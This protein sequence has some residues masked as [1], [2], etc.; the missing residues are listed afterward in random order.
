M[1]WYKT[2]QQ[3]H[4]NFWDGSQK[5]KYEIK[6]PNDFNPS[7]PKGFSIQIQPDTSIEDYIEEA[8]NEK[9]LLFLFETF[10]EHYDIYTLKN[11]E[12]VL[13]YDDKIIELS[14]GY[15]DIQNAEQWV[16]DQ[17]Q[18]IHEY[19]D[20]RDFNEEFWSGVGP[21]YKMYHG[22]TNE[23]IDNILKVGLNPRNGTRGISN[24]SIGAGIFMSPDP[25]T[26]NY[27]YD[28]VV[29]IDVGQMKKDGYTPFVSG[30]TPVDDAILLEALAHQL[31]I[32]S[33]EAMSQFSSDG[34]SQD[35][36]VFYKKIPPKYLKEFNLS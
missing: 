35:T 32:P 25:M 31:D 13:R 24:R 36:I 12:R 17:E 4:F 8:K 7:I 19:V 28:K 14:N 16:W 18:N 30:E 5:E 11:N 20:I 10:N 26:A 29:E 2:A 33:F 27:Y 3:N 23:N 21:G 22:T 34:L 9:E 6:N 1:N 15:Y